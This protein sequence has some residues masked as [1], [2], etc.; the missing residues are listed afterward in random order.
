MTQCAGPSHTFERAR[1]P[2]TAAMKWEGGVA[3]MVLVALFV[4]SRLNSRTYV[5][6]REIEDCAAKGWRS[7]PAGRRT[8]DAFNFNMELDILEARLRELR[9]HVD[10]FVLVEA[11]WT[12]AGQRKPLH[13][14]AAKAR[15]AEFPIT[16]VVLPEP[17]VPAHFFP[18][19]E[20][21]NVYLRTLMRNGL[22]GGLARAGAR[23]GDLVIVSDLDEVPRRNVVAQ[24][25][26]CEGYVT[27]VEVESDAY[28]YDFGCKEEHGAAWSAMRVLPFEQL[29]AECD[30]T[31]DG[32]W[33]MDELRKSAESGYVRYRAAAGFP[34]SLVVHSGGVHMS[35]FLSTDLIMTKI[36]SNSHA[37]KRD[38]PSINNR[39]HLECLI[40]KCLHPNL[41]D[42]GTRH[43]EEDPLVPIGADFAGY[44]SS[45]AGIREFFRRTIDWGAC[46]A[47][48]EA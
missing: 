33:C 48:G 31:W 21:Y 23:A 40:S 2:T 10:S 37:W 3:G 20:A 4:I 12:C 24:L 45:N 38:K 32:A 7:A 46:A 30:G 18:G 22:H 1:D 25:S 39:D 13:F 16:H 11:P 14:E 8:F 41:R 47:S 19:T 44:N 17:D 29:D 26:R 43:R 15:F 35:Y 36:S 28:I 9:G 6:I 27:P 42:H 5:A 34:K